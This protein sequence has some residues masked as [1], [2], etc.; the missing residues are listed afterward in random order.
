MKRRRNLAKSMSVF[1]ADSV[2]GH[3]KLIMFSQD[4]TKRVVNKKL[5]Q[6]VS[7]RFR[8]NL[9][10][11][12]V[13]SVK[14]ASIN[15]CILSAATAEQKLL[16]A[17]AGQ[18]LGKPYNRGTS[19]PKEFDSG[20]LM[21]YVFATSLGIQLPQEMKQLK[22]CGWIIPLTA[23]QPG[24]LLFC[25]T[26]EKDLRVGIYIGMELVIYAQ[27]KKQVV[28]VESLEEF[29]PKFAKRLFNNHGE[30]FE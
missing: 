25:D 27:L 1:L 17:T 22:K 24:D 6:E 15:D 23:I 10:Q 21:K 28:T 7:E 3:P 18:Q 11:P 13:S 12:Q 29:Q 5:T 2:S 26:K 20:G 9:E 19:G 8:Y 14:S 16:I 30:N 4:Y